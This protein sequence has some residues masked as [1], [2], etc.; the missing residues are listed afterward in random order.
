MRSAPM[1]GLHHRPPRKEPSM[2]RDRVAHFAALSD[3]LTAFRHYMQSE[4]GLAENTL[5]AYGR[6]LDRYAGWVAGGGLD[7]YLHPSLRDLSHY[8]DFL[9]EESL[10]PPSVA[11]HLV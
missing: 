10:A 3:D 4:R 6:D 1:N 2:P 7:D 11:R 9:R 8:L 5:L